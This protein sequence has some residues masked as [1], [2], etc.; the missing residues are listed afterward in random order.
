MTGDTQG[1]LVAAV[2]DHLAPMLVGQDARNWPALRPALHRSLVGNGGA[3]SAMELAVLD[4]VGRA[5]GQRLIDLIGRPRR[6]AVKPM[7][8][9]GNDTAEADVAEAHAKQA[10]GFHFFKLK[11][12]VK[13]LKQEIAIAFAVREALP[14]TPLCADANCG[15][16]L[17]AAQTY[18]EN[19]RKVGLMFVEQP[20]AYDDIEGLRKLARGTKVPIG[21]DEGIHSLADITTSARAGA[22]GVSLKLIKLGGIVAALE[23]ARLCQRLDLSVNIAAKIAESSISSAAALHL[24]CA[25]PKANWGVSLTHFYLAEDIVRRPLPLASGMVALP[26]GPGLG[27]EVDEATVERFRA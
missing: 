16:T 24:A 9:L 10:E 17:K 5:N 15:L 2:R 13:P 4:L 7:W 3:H 8:L 25:V 22:G 18:I 6:G 23:A 14:R 20:L 11:I 12:G 19:T 21:I 27:V 26:E 1:G